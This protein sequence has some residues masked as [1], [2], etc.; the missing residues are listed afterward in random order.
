M[1]FVLFKLNFKNLCEMNLELNIN[2]IY[3]FK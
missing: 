2:I 1:N 3:K